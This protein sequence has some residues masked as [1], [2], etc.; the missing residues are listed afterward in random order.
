MAE[1][2]EKA[3]ADI[4]RLELG[5]LEDWIKEQQTQ[6]SK[7]IVNIDSVYELSK[8]NLISTNAFRH[9]EIQDQLKPIQDRSN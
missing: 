4:L 2:V 5:S 7:D 1:R 3:A 6:I 9:E 8:N